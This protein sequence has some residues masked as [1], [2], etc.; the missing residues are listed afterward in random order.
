MVAVDVV[1]SDHCQ[2]VPLNIADFGSLRNTLGNKHLN[3]RSY[4]G[5]NPKA[6]GW[7]TG[8]SEAIKGRKLVPGTSMSR[9]PLCPPR[10]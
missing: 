5:G 3:I 9:S 7:E 8:G 2:D 4:L 1:R 10:V 6:H